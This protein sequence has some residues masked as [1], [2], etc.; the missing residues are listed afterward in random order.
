MARLKNFFKY[1]FFCFFRSEY[2]PKCFNVK[3]K[4]EKKVLN[5]ESHRYNHDRWYRFEE[6]HETY[7]DVWY[8]PN[9]GYIRKGKTMISTH[10]SP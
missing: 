10:Y 1:L 2:C 5:I 6:I 7:R 8:C 3:L 9:C 4:Y